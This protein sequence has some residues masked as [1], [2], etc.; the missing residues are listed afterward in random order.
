MFKHFGS[1]PAEVIRRLPENAKSKGLIAARIFVWSGCAGEPSDPFVSV[2][3]PPS[4]VGLH[5]IAKATSR[6]VKCMNK[7]MKSKLMKNK[8]WIGGTILLLAVTS[9]LGAENMNHDQVLHHDRADFYHAN[10]LSMDVFGMASLWESTIDHLSAARVQHQTQ[11]GAGLGLN[12]FLTRNFGIGADVY[13]EYTTG[14]F[15]DS[16]SVNLI[17]R[18][19]LGH[20]GFAPYAFGGGGRQ[21]DLTEAWFGQIGAGMEYRFTHHVGAFLDARWVLP[22]E[23]KGYGVARLGFRFSF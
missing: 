21:F 3:Q 20:S 18:L 19:P 22:G 13:A 14:A 5:P 17:L 12:Y 10:E 23:T 8:M 6:A 7:L 9:A 2:T 4:L 16:A 1:S 11:F 15:I